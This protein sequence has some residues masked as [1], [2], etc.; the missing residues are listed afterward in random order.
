MPSDTPTKCRYMQAAC[1]DL[2]ADDVC[3]EHDH[4]KDVFDLATALATVF[5]GDP[6]T[7]E[8][9]AWFL[10]DAQA[11]VTDYLAHEGS[12]FMWQVRPDNDA[13]KPPGVIHMLKVNNVQYVIQDSDWEPSVPERRSTYLSDHDL[14][15]EDLDDDDV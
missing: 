15:E 8:Q 9:I 4:T 13:L 10:N 14:T 12:P 11:V 6:P 7:D 1:P 5:Q 2:M 3:S